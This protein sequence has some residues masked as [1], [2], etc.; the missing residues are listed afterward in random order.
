MK[1]IASKNPFVDLPPS[2]VNAVELFAG[3][4]ASHFPTG[5]PEFKGGGS[6]GLFEDP[7]IHWANDRLRALGSGFAEAEVL[8]LGPLEGGHTYMFSQLGAREIVALEAN[9]R[10][11]LKCLVTKEVLGI[12]R[13]RFLLGNA[14]PFL[15]ENQRMFDVGVACAFLNHM[16]QP[17]EVIELLARSCRAVVLWNVVFSPALFEKQPALKPTFGP[18]QRSIWKGFEHTLHPHTYTAG[19]GYRTFWGGM[20][21]S[22]CWME[23]TDIVAALKHFG[24][25]HVTWSEDDCVFGKAFSAVAVR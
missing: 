5:F 22:C 16:L 23:S 9:G 1:D 7:R 8:E 13:A 17:V 19:F 11:F 21:S 3:E 24:Y 4:W 25:T 2:P 12:E 15:R 6:A 18:P 14:L 20:A 10:A